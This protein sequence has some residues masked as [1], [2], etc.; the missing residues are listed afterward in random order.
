MPTRSCVTQPKPS[1]QEQR[2]LNRHR[3]IFYRISEKI[4]N[5]VQM[6]VKSES[7]L[8]QCARNKAFGAVSI[9]GTVVTCLGWVIKPDV[10]V[11]V[12][13]LALTAIILGNASWLFWT[14]YSVAR[15]KI[16]SALPHVISI[17]DAGPKLPN[18]SAV[19]LITPSDLFFDAT[20]VSVYF[21]G[22]DGL[23]RLL[24]IGSVIEV[25]ADGKLQIGIERDSSTADEEM[26]KLIKSEHSV[27]E[28]IIVKP[29]ISRAY[30]DRVERWKRED[31]RSENES[32]KIEVGTPKSPTEEE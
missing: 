13:A 22:K 26:Q 31:K 1:R 2:N 3:G 20:I 15:S 7:I 18:Y 23:E 19:L 14:A 5:L 24:G 6:T 28:S 12:W 29:K 21:I 8:A 17:N 25:Q 32:N 10:L 11:P 9:V 30:S 27:S 4:R 16:L